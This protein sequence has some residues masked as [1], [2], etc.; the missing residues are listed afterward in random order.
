[1]S[2][3]FPF[4]FDCLLLRFCGS[5]GSHS[6]CDLFAQAGESRNHQLK[7]KTQNL[8]VNKHTVVFVVFFFFP[9]ALI[10]LRCLLRAADVRGRL[11]FLRRRKNSTGVRGN[12]LEKALRNNRPS[13]GEVLRWAESLEALLS[14]QYGLT[15]FRH[16]LRS[17]FSEENLD[18]WLAV[19]RFKRTRPSSKM[20][21]RAAKIYDQFIS[22]TAVNMD[23]AIRE[24]TNQSM[25]LGISSA[26]F[27][28]A[29]DQIFYL[30]E[31]DSYPRFLKSRFYTQLASQNTETATDFS[32]SS[33]V[34]LCP[35]ARITS[36][37]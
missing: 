16:F 29:Q 15:V 37:H 24:A 32:T 19:E 25:R 22:T 31:T 20:A 7:K 3:A 21:A 1:M 18:F 27:Q 4:L 9:V 10:R 5:S 36:P 13:A 30:M 26:S 28:L 33:L 2:V 12:S 35:S 6:H 14:N 17:E 34:G 11:A 23:S 8:Y